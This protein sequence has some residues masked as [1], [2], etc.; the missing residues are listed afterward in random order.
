MSGGCP[1]DYWWIADRFSIMVDV[2]LSGYAVAMI[3]PKK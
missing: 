2:P 1:V 3:V